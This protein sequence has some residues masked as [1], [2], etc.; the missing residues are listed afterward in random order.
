M[1]QNATG[2]DT[3]VLGTNLH[4]A[5]L[6]SENGKLDIDKLKTTPVDLSK[7]IDL[8]KSKV[9]K[10]TLYDELAKKV[11]AIQTTDTRSFV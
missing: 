7:L 9:V 8:V 1:Q 10:K 2:V 11:S 3:S 4:L 6:K 5:S